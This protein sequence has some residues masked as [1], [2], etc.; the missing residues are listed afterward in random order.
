MIAGL[1]YIVKRNPINHFEQSRSRCIYTGFTGQLRKR[2]WQHKTHELIGFTEEYQCE[3]L[4]W[5]QM[6]HDPDSAIT[7]DL[8]EKWY[9]TSDVRIARAQ[10]IC[11]LRTLQ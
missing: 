6:F 8:S 10:N 2:I 11:K 5:A 3:R 4:E 1:T 7:R 9:D